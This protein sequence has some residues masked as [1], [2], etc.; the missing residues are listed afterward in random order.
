MKKITLLFLE[1]VRWLLAFLVLLLLVV[2]ATVDLF[3][4][5]LQ[6]TALD[7]A[8]YASVLAST[9]FVSRSSSLVA[10]VLVSSISRS[11]TTPPFFKTIPARDWDMAFDN[12]LPQAWVDQVIHA[13][14]TSTL[15]WI[16]D[17]SRPLPDVTVDLTPVKEGVQSS[18]G[19]LAILQ[20]LQNAPTCLTARNSITLWGEDI[21][22]CLPPAN[23]LVY[24]S[25]LFAIGIVNGMANQEPISRLLS[26][27][28]QA[29]FSKVRAAID[30]YTLALRTFDRLILLLLCLYLL[31][32]SITLRRLLSSLKWPF[33]LAGGASLLI[34]GARLAV[35]ILD[36]NLMVRLLPVGLQTETQSL[37][38]DVIASIT[39]LLSQHW[40]PWA[41]GL[42][43]I[44]LAFHG[45]EIAVGRIAGRLNGQ[46]QAMAERP[47]RIRGQFR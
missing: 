10:D 13:M 44:G 21:I 40:L 6:S 8:S 22:T 9:R 25:R 11:T 45:L 27:N 43:L 34:L 39:G 38:V 33:Y 15:E 35:V 28:A 23:N 19:A 36:Q 1:G 17:S 14:V 24:Y 3:G 29:I 41:V 30:V 32:N 31:L 7:P 4:R 37:L 26:F 46:S 20:L 16:A 42:I 5:A 2:T 47:L 12:I 18:N